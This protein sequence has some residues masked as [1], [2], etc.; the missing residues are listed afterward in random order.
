M[1]IFYS[2]STEMILRFKILYRTYANFAKR[3]FTSYVK[4]AKAPP[5]TQLLAPSTELAV[6][7]RTNLGL[8]TATN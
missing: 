1:I 4:S 3:L 2:K 7:Q 6:L 5:A 8:T